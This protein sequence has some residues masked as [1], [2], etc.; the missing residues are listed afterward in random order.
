MRN[1]IN[2]KNCGEPNPFYNL[3]CHFCKSL[4]R[5]RVVNIDF[6]RTVLKLLESP[7][8]GFTEIIYSEH[9]NF[10]ITLIFLLSI[11]FFLNSILVAGYSKY[12]IMLL[13]ILFWMVLLYL[14]VQ[15]S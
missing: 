1:S 3:N 8:K 7:V 13:I 5:N 11:K 9:K 12:L 6:G 10:V 2:C 15:S 4:L 14:E